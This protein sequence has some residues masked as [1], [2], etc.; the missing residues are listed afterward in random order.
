VRGRLHLRGQR[1]KRLEAS[2][3]T[4][5]EYNCI[6]Q[7]LLVKM[8]KTSYRPLYTGNIAIDPCLLP[9]VC[10]SSN[11]RCKVKYGASF[12]LHGN[13]FFCHDGC[14]QLSGSNIEAGVIDPIES[15]RSEHDLNLLGLAVIGVQ[16]T[17][18][19]TCLNWRPLF[20]RNAVTGY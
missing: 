11:N 20:D 1:C 9:V 12:G 13:P 14:H 3:I 7:I 4:P 16:D 15:G 8:Y 18:N 2:A 17:A 5:L 19:K 6:F 10:N